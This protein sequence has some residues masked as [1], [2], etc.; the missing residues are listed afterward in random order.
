MK[1]SFKSERSAAYLFDHLTNMDKF[2]AVHP[3]ISKID[4]IGNN[5]YRVHETLKLG[6]IPVSF[7]YPVI[8]TPYPPENMVM[9][10]ATVMGLTTVEMVFTITPGKTFTFIDEQISFS[11]PMPVQSLLKK[12]FKNQHE[13]L[14]KNIELAG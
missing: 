2:A 6:I 12:I 8:I 5:C 11:S 3:V 1:L 13:Q 7:T 14:F 10:R 4:R 9:M